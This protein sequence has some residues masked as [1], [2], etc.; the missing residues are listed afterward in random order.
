MSMDSEILKHWE[1]YRPKTVAAL[2]AAGTLDQTV[3]EA[4]QQHA[5]TMHE[6]WKKGLARDQARE[7]AQEPWISPESETDFEP[8]T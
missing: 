3:A 5:E 4:A 8:E 6:L 1:K 7:V 2:R